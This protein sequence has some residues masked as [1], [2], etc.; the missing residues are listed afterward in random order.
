MVRQCLPYV[1]RALKGPAATLPEHGIKI[2]VKHGYVSAYSLVFTQRCRLLVQVGLIPT[3][4]LSGPCMR[5][6]PAFPACLLSNCC[7]LH[8]TLTLHTVGPS[9]TLPETFLPL[10]VRP[11]CMLPYPYTS[12]STL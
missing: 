9:A 8:A 4:L 11:T 1:C 7:L 3:R 6:N 10:Y 12:P 5:T 2:K